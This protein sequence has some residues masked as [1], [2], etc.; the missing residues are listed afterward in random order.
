MSARGASTSDEIGEGF[1][2]TIAVFSDQK[3]LSRLIILA[4]D[5]RPGGPDR[6]LQAAERL[7]GRIGDHVQLFRRDFFV[8]AA[9]LYY[10]D[11]IPTQGELLASSWRRVD[12]IHASV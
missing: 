9:C 12:S 8:L 10:A 6:L 5:G 4:S 1:S 3:E 2:H 7:G 11:R